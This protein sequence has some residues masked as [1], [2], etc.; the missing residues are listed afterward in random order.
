MCLRFQVNY[1]TSRILR[2]SLLHFLFYDVLTALILLMMDGP[3]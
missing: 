1:H 3:E 2:I